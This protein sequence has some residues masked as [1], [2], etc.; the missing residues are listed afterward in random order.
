MVA[1]CRSVWERR[2][3]WFVKEEKI[4]QGRARQDTVIYVDSPSANQRVGHLN[5]GIGQP[6]PVFLDV[7]STPITHSAQIPALPAIS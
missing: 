6:H 3:N 7:P 2:L 4:E 5:H 1:E